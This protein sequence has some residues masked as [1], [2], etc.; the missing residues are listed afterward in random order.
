MQAL[1]VAP[2]ALGFQPQETSM[3]MIRSL[4]IVTALCL[5]GASASAGLTMEEC[6]AKYKATLAAKTLGTTWVAF[7]ETE[8]GISAK[9]TAPTP[10]PAAPKPQPVQRQ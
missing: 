1:I 8:C 9:A 10:P 3:M 5:F 6:K 4:V 2:A 7:Q